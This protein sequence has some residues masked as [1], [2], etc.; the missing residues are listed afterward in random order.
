MATTVDIVRLLREASYAYYEGHHL[1]MDNDTYDGIVERL[2]E[3][4]PLN[5][6]LKEAGHPPSDTPLKEIFCLTAQRDTELQEKLA[7]KG[8][9]YTTSL[10]ASCSILVT[11][12]TEA[13]DTPKL[14]VARELGIKI[15]TRAQV[16]Q[17]YLS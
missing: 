15:L 11:P 16:L 6:Y 3:L 7:Q 8:L 9:H 1:T 12:D 14:R 2:R 13:T 4:D 17:Q 5:P 10:S